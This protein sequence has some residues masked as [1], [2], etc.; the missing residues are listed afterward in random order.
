M[1]EVS[2]WKLEKPL[3]ESL[4]VETAHLRLAGEVV[5]EIAVRHNNAGVWYAAC[6]TFVIPRGEETLVE[7]DSIEK[8]SFKEFAL[9]FAEASGLNQALLPRIE[10]LIDTDAER[11]MEETSK[12]N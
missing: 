5:T 10:C 2:F 12:N 3:G 7:M 9:A 1:S 8:S 4:G 11:Y 6:G